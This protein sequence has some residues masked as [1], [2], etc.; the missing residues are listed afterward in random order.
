[1][2]NKN[3]IKLPFSDA[4][5]KQLSGGH[6]VTSAADYLQKTIIREMPD[7]PLKGLELGSGNGIITIMLLLQRP[8]WQLTGI[9]LQKEL[10]DIAEQNRRELN[11][12]CR[13][14][15]GDIRTCRT[16]LAHQEYDLVYSNPPWVKLGSG[17]VSPD[18]SRALS[19]QE[20]ACS[21]K[22]VLNCIEWCLNM[23]GT[24]FIVYPSE[25]KTELGLEIMRTELEVLN[26][27][28]AEEFGDIFVAKLRHKPPVQSW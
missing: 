24:A 3:T 11:L 15:Q 21:M 17:L 4:E 28:K 5:I 13:F 2:N 22:D 20:I 27:Y 1:M 7:M 25:R 9:E 23:D 14:E 19:R 10:S 16:K 12:A 8:N 18:E 26:L 6:P